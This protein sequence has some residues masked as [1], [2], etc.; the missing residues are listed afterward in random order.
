MHLCGDLNV[1]MEKKNK[2]SYES[3]VAKYGGPLLKRRLSIKRIG[4][5]QRQMTIPRQIGVAK[6]AILLLEVCYHFGP[7]NHNSLSARK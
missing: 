6:E 7:G 5:R 2:I 1:E 4:L 3:G